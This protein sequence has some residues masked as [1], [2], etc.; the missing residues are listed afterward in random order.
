MFR[1]CPW[2]STW[3]AF[4]VPYISRSLNSSVQCALIIFVKTNWFSEI[5]SIFV[6]W[7]CA[8]VCVCVCVCMCVC[9]FGFKRLNDDL[10]FSRKTRTT[11][12]GEKLWDIVIALKSNWFRFQISVVTVLQPVNKC[13]L[14][15]LI[16][17][18]TKCDIFFPNCLRQAQL[19]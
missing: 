18:R 7:V 2:R 9:V 4:S 15:F 10:L 19:D 5:C 3:C 6:F 16:Y 13:Q 11:Q 8:C 12:Y 14:P 1:K 17:K